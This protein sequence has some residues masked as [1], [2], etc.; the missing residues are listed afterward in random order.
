MELP[1]FLLVFLVCIAVLLKVSGP[2]RK[3]KNK[4]RSKSVATGS[5]AKVVATPL[6]NASERKIFA[7]LS[8]LIA[9]SQGGFRLF[10]QVAIG[11][12]LKIERAGISASEWTTFFNQINGKRVDFL[13]VDDAW[14]P[15]AAIEYQG[16]G[17]YR[18][19]AEKRDAIKREA[20]RKAGIPFIE[21]PADGLTPSQVAALKHLLGVPAQ[22]AAE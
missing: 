20:C 11:E 12:V 14:A 15:V 16:R 7:A 8:G 4:E 3:R 5:D 13:V 1:V 21:I 19:D 6:L 22:V 2:S 9:E 10:A 17:H 18:G